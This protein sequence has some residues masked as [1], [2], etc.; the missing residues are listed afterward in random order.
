MHTGYT[1]GRKLKKRMWVRFAAKDRHHG[2]LDVLCEQMRL[3]TY[4]ALLIYGYIIREN[5]ILDSYFGQRE[6]IL[7]LDMCRSE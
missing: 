6:N 5:E 3:R 7:I 4:W 1:S 2:L